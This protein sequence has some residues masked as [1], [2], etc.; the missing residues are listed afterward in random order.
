MSN[1]TATAQ[2]PGEIVEDVLLNIVDNDFASDFD[3]FDEEFGGESSGVED[4]YRVKFN[5]G[6]NENCKFLGLE[7]VSTETYKMIKV[8]FE[9]FDQWE[10]S[11]PLFVP[12]IRTYKDKNGIEVTSW[13]PKKMFDSNKMPIEDN[14]QHRRR[15]FGGVP[16]IGDNGRTVRDTATKKIIYRNETDDE[17]RIRQI[18]TFK[19]KL[20]VF[21][22]SFCRD[23]MKEA[24][25]LIAEAGR[26]EGW[27]DYTERIMSAIQHF[28]PEYYTIPMRLKLHRKYD[29]STS[30]G[31]SEKYF[32]LPETLE[33]GLFLEKM[34]VPE[35]SVITTTAYE[36]RK[37]IAAPT[38]QTPSAGVNQIGG[39]P[40]VAPMGMPMPGLPG[41]T[42]STAM[43]P[44]NR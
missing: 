39:M 41:A 1:A 17:A 40:G 21:L 8:K 18:K 37:L 27:K 26:V 14:S 35:L 4:L 28:S 36:D 29:K 5:A 11:F 20:N 24:M 3:L 10:D 34:C 12:E 13:F 31:R 38:T 32:E 6:I 16:V 2:E 22:A 9:N 44:L 30:N 42:V 25:Q 33:Y 23:T 15:H 7:W 19:Q 43:P